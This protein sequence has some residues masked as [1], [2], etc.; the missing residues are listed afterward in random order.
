VRHGRGAE[1]YS[2]DFSV[3]LPVSMGRQTQGRVFNLK[4]NKEPNAY[5]VK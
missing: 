3:R 1:I 4:N 2:P 5:V